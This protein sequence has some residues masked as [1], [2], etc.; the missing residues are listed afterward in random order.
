MAVIV[1]DYSKCNGNGICVKECSIDLLEVTQDGGWCKPKDEE[2]SNNNTVKEFYEKIR[3]KSDFKMAF[4]V[5]NCA[6][7]YRC[8]TSCPAEAIEVK[9]E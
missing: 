3:G 8:E 4:E 9:E 7:C 5:E 6:E 1:F 2:V